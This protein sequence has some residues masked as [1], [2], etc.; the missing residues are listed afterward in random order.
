MPAP[1]E[2]KGVGAHEAKKNAIGRELLAKGEK[3]VESVVGGAGGLRLIGK[4][5]GKTGIVCNGETSH[6]EAVGEGGGGTLRLERLFPDWRK[7]D[8]VEAERSLGGTSNLEMAEVRRIKTA[9][10][11]SHAQ[12]AVGLAAFGVG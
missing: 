6:G 1:E 8:G 5:D 12:T 11:E 4:R 3:S 10:K 2:G 7:E 9:S